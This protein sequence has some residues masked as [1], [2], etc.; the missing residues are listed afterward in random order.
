MTA[1]LYQQ[2]QRTL[3][4]SVTKQRLVNTDSEYCSEECSERIRVNVV[5]T[6]S[7]SLQVVN[8]SNYQS[9]IS[10]YSL[11]WDN[12]IDWSKYATGRSS[13]RPSDN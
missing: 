13:T 10:A 4:G 11:N 1:T 5:I 12:V 8:K 9:K 2:K 3:L 6:C 7:C